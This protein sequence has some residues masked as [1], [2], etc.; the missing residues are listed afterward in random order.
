MGLFQ[1]A[2]TRAREQF[3]KKNKLLKSILLNLFILLF[4]QNLFANSD[5]D[6]LLDK[7]SL[8]FSSL[9]EFS[10]S[11]I[12]QNESSLQEGYFYKN[13]KRI[14]VD[15]ISPNKIT[16][17]LDKNKAMFFNHEL[18][19]VEYFNPKK[20]VAKIIFDIFNNGFVQKFDSYLIE[21]NHSKFYISLQED[22]FLYIVEVVFETNP[23]QLRLVNIDNGEEKLSFGLKDHNFNN[24]FDKNFFSMAN[25]L[26]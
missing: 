24:V 23:L 17:I 13:N 4:C 20:T 14:K 15:Y 12:Q 16:I 10:A 8:Y 1:Q 25:P 19:E 2:I 7:V 21:D 5:T 6:I 11:F 3:W 18:R 26:N 9:D 22:E